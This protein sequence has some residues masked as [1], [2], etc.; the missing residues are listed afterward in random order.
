MKRNR[1]QKPNQEMP[2]VCVL[3]H[4]PAAITAIYF[5]G[6]RRLARGRIYVYG[7]C[8]LCFAKSD[9]AERVECKIE[10]TIILA[11]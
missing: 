11:N 7:L 1:M 4:A 3:C 5:P 8:G 9:H 10:A 6:D 2:K